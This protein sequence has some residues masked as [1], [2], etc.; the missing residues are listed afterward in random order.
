[1]ECHTLIILIDETDGCEC[2]QDYLFYR[3]IDFGCFKAFTDPGL[4]Y[5]QKV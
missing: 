3:S 4:W 5:T 2:L 1:M